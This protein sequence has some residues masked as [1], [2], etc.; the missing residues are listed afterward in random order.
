MKSWQREFP[1]PLSPLICSA[2]SIVH[3]SNRGAWVY[4]DP[5]FWLMEMPYYFNYYNSVILFNILLS[6]I[7]EL[8]SLV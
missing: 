3:L 8:I 2:A 7:L 5:F 1:T 4:S 6:H